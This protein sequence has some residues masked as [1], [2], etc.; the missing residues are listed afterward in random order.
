MSEPQGIDE[1]LQLSNSIDSLEL[2]PWGSIGQPAPEKI[3]RYQAER[4]SQLANDIT[5][6]KTPGGISMKKKD[7]WPASL[8]HVMHTVATDIHETRLE[9]KQLSRH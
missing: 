1:L 9:R 2:H 7:H 8:V 3:R 5:V 4:I 6:E